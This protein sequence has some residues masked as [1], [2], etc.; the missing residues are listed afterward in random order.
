MIVTVFI[1]KAIISA[2]ASFDTF[3]ESQESEDGAYLSPIYM[4]GLPHTYTFW[5]RYSIMYNSINQYAYEADFIDCLEPASNLDILYSFF[6]YF[7]FG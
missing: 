2:T 3:L 7:F 6:V 5:N 1:P 4:E